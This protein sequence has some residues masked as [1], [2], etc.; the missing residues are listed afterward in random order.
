MGKINPIRFSTKCTDDESDFLYYGK[1][2]YNPSTG[3]WLSRDP[4]GEAGGPNLYGFAYNDGINAI[5]LLGLDIVCN[6]PEAYFKENGITPEMYTKSGNTYSAKS[7]ASGPTSGAGLILWR[8]LLT[9]HTFTAKDLKVDELKKHVSARQTI[10]NNALKANF[11]FGTGQK[12]DWKG[13]MQD[14]QAFF[15]KLNTGETVIACKALA[16]IIFETGNK[17]KGIG[18]RNVDRIWIPGDWGYIVNKAAERNPS[19]WR[20]G[21]EGENVFHTGVS[22]SDELFWGHFK[23]GQHPSLPEKEW[24]DQIRKEWPRDGGSKNGEPGEPEWR[25]KLKYPKIGLQ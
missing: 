2:Y 18:A 8:M 15:D 4:I 23:D 21:R 20:D 12:L 17:F 25:P 22:G 10:V 11:K 14:P 5:D 13:F 19:N 16:E 9:K 7:G 6:C 24:F 3:R 1:R